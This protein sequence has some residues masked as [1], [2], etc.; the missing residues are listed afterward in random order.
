[1]KHNN[2]TIREAVKAWLKDQESAEK[3]YGQNNT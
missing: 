3:K 2:E 1:M